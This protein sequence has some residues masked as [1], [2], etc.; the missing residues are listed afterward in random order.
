M[1]G[2]LR[3][4]IRGGQGES[5]PYATWSGGDPLAAVRQG[6]LGGPTSQGE[7]AQAGSVQGG[8]D[9]GTLLQG[10]LRDAGQAPQSYDQQLGP[11]LSRR[12][13]T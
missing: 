5:S 12:G 10:V 7:N 2:L 6:L 1:E 4:P 13:W 11:V 3:A 8:P 9:L